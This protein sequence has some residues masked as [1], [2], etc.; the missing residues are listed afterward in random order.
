[1]TETVSRQAVDNE[2]LPSGWLKANVGEVCSIFAGYKFPKHFQ[3]R[4]EGEVPFFKVRDISKSVTI[5]QNHLTKAEHYISQDETIELKA[6]PFPTGSVV[7]AKFGEAIRLNRRAIL[8]QDS[9]VDNNVMGLYAPESH[10]AYK[11]L[12]YWMLTVKLDEIARAT[13]VPSIRKSDMEQLQIPLPPL[14][15]QRRIVQKIEELFT[16]LDAGVQSLKQT[17]A[18]LKCYRRSVLKAAVEGELSREWREAHRDELEPASE[19]LERILQERREKFT[20]KKYK[21]PAYPDTS[22]LPALPDR[23]KWARAEQLCDFITKGTTPKADKLSKVGDVPFIKVYNLT[24]SGTLNFSI[25]PT[26][27]DN[28]THTGCLSR[29]KVYPGDVL[30]NI[31]GP[32]LGKVSITPDIYPEWNINQAIAVFRSLPSYET[33]FLSYLLMTPQILDWA[34]RRAKATAGQFNLTLAI[35]RDLPLPVPSLKE[36]HFIVEEVERRLSVV[37]KLEATVEANLKQADGLRQS[38]LK[39]AFSGEL[40]P[41][42]LDDEPAK[43]LLERIR[44]EPQATKPKARVRREINASPTKSNHAEQRGL[45]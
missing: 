16:K 38:I 43:V 10:L 36:Q 33:K 28:E 19:L 12:Y 40:V 29:S 13:A 15:E 18:L 6:S 17:Q 35:C 39:Q 14:N 37:D 11:Y 21:E 34:K 23:W 24:H 26:F 41:Q 1:V 20:S 44:G 2:T 25:N 32:P 22:K 5:G 4:P 45:F 3:G 42:D 31:V 9:L 8:A 27:V 30:M 7:F